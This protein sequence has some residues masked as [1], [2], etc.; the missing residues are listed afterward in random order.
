MTASTPSHTRAGGDSSSGSQRNELTPGKS[1]AAGRRLD[2]TTIWLPSSASMRQRLRPI[3][4]VAP[5][6]RIFIIFA[7]VYGGLLAQYAS[8][9]SYGEAVSSPYIINSSESRVKALGSINW[10]YS[11]EMKR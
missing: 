5:V 8:H 11:R 7:S 10:Y 6:I 9:G 4:P 2:K 3:S 1:I